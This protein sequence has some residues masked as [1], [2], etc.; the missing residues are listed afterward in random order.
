MRIDNILPRLLTHEGQ[1]SAWKS[2]LSSPPEAV[3]NQTAQHTRRVSRTRGKTKTRW[4]EEKRRERRYEV[5]LSLGVNPCGERWGGWH[6]AV[7]DVAASSPPPSGIWAVSH[8]TAGALHAQ[9]DM[10]PCL[11]GNPKEGRFPT[12]MARGWVCAMRVHLDPHYSLGL[13]Q[14]T[15][16]CARGAPI[17]HLSEA[18]NWA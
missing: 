4:T 8:L 18:V 3:T 11:S 15:A 9:T 1:I 13:V 14:T 2:S 12:T 5:Q 6:V 7:C 16:G 10:H 17:R